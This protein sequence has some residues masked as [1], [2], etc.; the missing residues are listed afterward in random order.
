[1]GV[2]H[3]RLRLY[4]RRR[5]WCHLV[6]LAIATI[7]NFRNVGWSDTWRD[8]WR[9]CRQGSWS[10]GNMGITP[11]IPEPGSATIQ[12][13]P[14]SQMSGDGIVIYHQVVKGSVPQFVTQLYLIMTGLHRRG[15]GFHPNKR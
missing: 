2:R 7:R 8:R 10:R 13:I 3:F 1:M 15:K 5:R 6:T 9:G 14:M 12:K 4:G 11:K